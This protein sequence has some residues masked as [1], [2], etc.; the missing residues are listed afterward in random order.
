MKRKEKAPSLFYRAAV[1]VDHVWHPWKWQKV[2]TEPA[3]L[4][5][6]SE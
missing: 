2:E 5:S 1:N 3:H 6:S 4:P